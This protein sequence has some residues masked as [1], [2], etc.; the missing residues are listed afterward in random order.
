MSQNTS[1]NC[2]FPDFETYTTLLE[3]EFPH[4]QGEIE[5]FS[6]EIIVNFMKERGFPHGLQNKVFVY[7][8]KLKNLKENVTK[9]RSLPPP[10]S[11][12]KCDDIFDYILKVEEYI[13]LY[14]VQDTDWCKVV[15]NSLITSNSTKFKELTSFKTIN[16]AKYFILTNFGNSKDFYKK[17]NSNL[18][19]LRLGWISGEKL[20]V[21]LEKFIFF[22]ELL[23]EKLPNEFIKEL[24][25]VKIMDIPNYVKN[26]Q[27][28]SLDDYCSSIIEIYGFDYGSKKK[29]RAR[30][31][32]KRTCF[33]C[34]QKGHLALN[35]PVA[36]NKKEKITRGSRS[37]L[38][39]RRCDKEEKN[40]RRSSDSN[41]EG[42]P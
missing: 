30:S 21:F 29:V 35:C 22:A 2:V 37:P 41:E 36:K 4:K 25:N 1:W 18:N 40:H 8:T 11:L 10:P 23:P 19:I 3:K 28:M 33:V 31:P 42:S 17:E 32:S 24:L 34:H 26:P 7:L 14:K 5:F 15:K 38:L 13:K 16:E 20:G 6:I 9:V 27:G 39:S 12:K